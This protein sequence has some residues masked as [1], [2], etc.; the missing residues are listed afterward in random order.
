MELKYSIEKVKDIIKNHLGKLTD[1]EVRFMKDLTV[2]VRN[3]YVAGNVM[4]S[5]KQFNILLKI[6]AKTIGLQK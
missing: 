4:V 1:W 2:W 3:V 5:E 6:E